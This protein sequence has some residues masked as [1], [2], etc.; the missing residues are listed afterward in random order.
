MRALPR[1]V[2]F[3]ADAIFDDANDH[4]PLVLE[5]CPKCRGARKY[6][7]MNEGTGALELWE[8]D[9]CRGCGTTGRAVPCFEN[10]STEREASTN[11]SGFLTC[12]GCNHRFTIRDPNA[13]TGRRCKK[14]G[15]KISIT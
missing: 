2:P 11:P 15:Q 5:P 14:C 8:C 1:G 9:V 4:N 7:I 13:W 3:R 12:P 10:Q 6:C